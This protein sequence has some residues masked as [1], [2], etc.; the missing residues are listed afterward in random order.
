M[1][2]K[3][4]KINF[5]MVVFHGDESHVIESVKTSPTKQIK[6]HGY[7]PKVKQL[8]PEK[9]PGVFSGKAQGRADQ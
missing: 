6:E 7:T 5:Q 9:L 4:P 2:G 1:F 3:E 8:A